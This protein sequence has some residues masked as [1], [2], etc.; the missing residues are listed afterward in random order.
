V[1]KQSKAAALK[2]V[3]AIED[4]IPFPLLPLFHC[5]ALQ[6]HADYAM[7]FPHPVQANSWIVRPNGNYL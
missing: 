5:P 2:A 1:T 4:N 7:N 3:I 6:R